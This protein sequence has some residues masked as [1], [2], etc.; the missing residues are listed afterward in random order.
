MVNKV[1]AYA[2]QRLLKITPLDPTHSVSS[3]LF[4]SNLLLITRTIYTL[5]YLI[6]LVFFL[7]YRPKEAYLIVAFLTPLAY[8]GIL[9]YLLVSTYLSWRLYLS[10]GNYLPWQGW[11]WSFPFMY[12]LHYE[13]N[14]SLAFV[15]SIVYWS[16]LASN[17]L[18]AN[19]NSVHLFLSISMHVMNSVIMWSEAIVGANPI[20]LRHFPMVLLVPLLYVPY[21]FVIHAR[22]GIWIY[23]FL[24]YNLNPP[25]TILIIV[26]II[27]MS[28]IYYPIMY[29]FHVA[30]DTYGK[31]GLNRDS[32]VF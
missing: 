11:H 5:F 30:R 19:P 32:I 15:V 17:D 23:P 22:Y 13:I 4:S 20:I 31:R 12:F 26:G 14:T 10:H 24:D 9:A 25:S 16:M 27:L 18:A 8:F 3:S 7:L 2:L 1:R 21:A 6:V 29:L 28:M